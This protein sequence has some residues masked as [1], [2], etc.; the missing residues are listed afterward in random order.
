MPRD[1]LL[2][3]IHAEAKAQGLDEDAR[4]D[5]M[6]RVTGKRSARDMTPAE[7][8]R[9]IVALKG[10]TSRSASPRAY[11]RG[12]AQHPQAA[13]ARALWLSLHLLGAV[14]DPAESALDAFACR[15]TGIAS[16]AWTQDPAEL[17]KVIEALKDWC[18]RAGVDWAVGPPTAVGGPRYA[19]GVA[20]WHK[21]AEAANSRVSFHV[22]SGGLAIGPAEL[23]TRPPAEADAIL[24]ALG[25]S[26]RAARGRAT[27]PPGAAPGAAS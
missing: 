10:G 12:A 23:V 17:R 13:K 18:A 25:S 14:E 26:L 22:A 9:V 8:E 27:A 6:E 4:R 19:V 24:R 7:R 2:A 5:L 20:L 11:P 21:I 16:L 15:Q 1:A 3:A